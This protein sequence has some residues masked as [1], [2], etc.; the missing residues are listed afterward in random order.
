M[1]NSVQAVQVEI[2]L[3]QIRERAAVLRG[4]QR[5]S[6]FDEDALRLAETLNYLHFAKWTTDAA[7]RDLFL[8]R[9]EGLVKGEYEDGCHVRLR[10][11]ASAAETLPSL[12]GKLELVGLPNM[13]PQLR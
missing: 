3:R 4:Y 6:A 13:L 2:T 8:T 1:K 7:S 12:C 10:Q 9:A 5:F 11:S